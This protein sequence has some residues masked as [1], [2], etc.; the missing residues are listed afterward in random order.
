MRYKKS[1]IGVGIL[2]TLI[3]LILLDIT[4]VAQT[5]PDIIIDMIWKMPVTSA[6]VGNIE[7]LPIMAD[8]HLAAGKIPCGTDRIKLGRRIGNIGRIKMFKIRRIVKIRRIH[9][10]I[11]L[12]A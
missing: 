3:F 1:S 11:N 12:I 2:A 6:L 5:R 9:R 10:F 4:A 8:Q 7:R